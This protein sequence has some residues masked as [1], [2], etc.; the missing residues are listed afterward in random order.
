M[1]G[2]KGRFKGGIGWMLIAVVMTAGRAEPVQAPFEGEIFYLVEEFREGL[3][4]ERTYHFRATPER[5]YL[6]SSH[7]H[8]LMRGVHA[9]RF[10]VRNDQ[11]NLVLIN[12]DQESFQVTG[13]E[14]EAL[15]QLIRQMKRGEAAPVDWDSRV[16]ETGRKMEIQGMQA[17]E[18]EVRHPDRPLMVSV[19]LTSEIQVAWG[20]LETLWRQSLSG[21]LEMDVPVEVFMNR[22]SFPLRIEYRE[23]GELTTRIEAVRIR[24]GVLSPSALEI[25][26]GTT[27]IGMSDLM[28]RMM[29]GS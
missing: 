17:V 18:F 26:E 15:A 22:N 10:L 3:P 11:R 16:R 8:V 25:P 23:D 1:R 29:R 9:N 5:M 13:E 12:R 21:L 6:E 7:S 24:R 2:W 27:P 20:Y 19:W 14:A 4:A 28:M